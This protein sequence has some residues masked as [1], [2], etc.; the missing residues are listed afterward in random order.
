MFYG[1]G[2]RTFVKAKQLRKN[3]TKT[4]SL[5][6]E[7][8]SNNQLDGI[9][10]R[11]QHPIANYIVDFYCHK[12]KLVIE[13]DGEYHR[14]KDQM[15]HDQKRDSTLKNL[16]LSILRFTNQEVHQNIDKVITKIRESLK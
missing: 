4:E 16:G 5:L 9:R 15:I 14:T 7:R 3:M 8:L 11:R 6:W 2:G 12:Y 10:F 1:A 13:V